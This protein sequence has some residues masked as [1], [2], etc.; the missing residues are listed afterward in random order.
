MKFS[1]IIPT[2]NSSSV[3]S[4]A[5][6]SVIAQTYS[7]WELIIIDDGSS[8][9]THDICMRYVSGDSRI[10]YIKQ[11]NQGPSSAR[12]HGIDFASGEF[13]TFLDSDDTYEP[14][15]LEVMN[16]TQEKTNCDVA[17]VGFRKTSNGKVL[18]EIK[19]QFNTKS[20]SNISQLGGGML[21]TVR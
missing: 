7:D 9:S 17:I 2:Y 1:I 3:I 5:I 20:N 18:K 14:T 13:I 6:E 12:N 15:F 16:A 11:T 4:C 21:L 8:D 10:N 19:P